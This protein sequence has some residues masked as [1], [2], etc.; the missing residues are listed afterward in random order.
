M[1]AEGSRVPETDAE[2]IAR[3]MRFYSAETL[4][5]LVLSQN[6]H[7]EKLQVYGAPHLGSEKAVHHVRE[8]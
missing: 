5:Q 8:G 2:I 4:E 1:N 6:K 7:V 3:L